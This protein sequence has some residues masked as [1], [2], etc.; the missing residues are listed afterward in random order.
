M[1]KSQLVPISGG[2]HVWTRKIGDSPVKMLILHGGPGSSHEYLEIFEDYLPPEGVEIYFYDQL[3]SY[4]SDQPDD[5][6]LWNVERFREEVEEVRNY[7]GLE[8]FYLC[9]QSWGGMLAMEYALKYQDA[10]KGLIISNMTASIP[11]YVKHIN[12]LRDALP[13]HLVATM[14]RYEAAEDYE[15]PEYQKLMDEHLNNKHICR[16]DPWPDAVVRGFTHM[17]P[18]VYN[19]MQGPNE[20]LVTG[21][22]KDWDRWDDIHNIQVP[23]LLLVGRHDSMDPADIEEM[24]RRIPDSRVGICETGSHLAMWDDSETY[25]GFIRDFVD[26][27]EKKH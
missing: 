14:K 1:G 23:T 6:S 2:F 15:A 8:N 17:N 27:L 4:Y 18:A 21:S 7:L 25:F 11:S 26:E 3:G 12:A 9:G 24:G 5:L 16:L 19:T 22:F 10:L 13:A 20:F